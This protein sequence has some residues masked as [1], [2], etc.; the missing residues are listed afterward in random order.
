MSK[1][2]GQA[3]PAA[4]PSARPKANARVRPNDR[5]SGGS[6]SR[7]PWLIAAVVVVIGIAALVAV[8]GSGGD[9]STADTG[10]ETATVTVTGAT[11]PE[12]DGS[13][14]IAPATDPAVGKTV[15]TL[16]GSSLSGT[17]VTFG[18]TGKPTVYVFVAHWC[19]HCQAE[20]PR[21]VEWINDGSFDASGVLWRT[22]STS[23]SKDQPNYPPS[24]WLAKV[25]WD[26]PV[27]VDSANS[28]AAQAF[29]LT[30]FP[31]MLFVDGNGVVKQRATGELT[32]AEV[33]QGIAAI[34]AASG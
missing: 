8:F 24:A 33:Q 17:P 18:P 14:L 29:G 4:R 16:S 28:A 34:G 20:M 5:A 6:A 19:P 22:V 1:T 11:L 10:N 15:P 30:S 9:D 26:Q 31:Y 3:R 21:L 23:V 7:M 12:A 2:A 27:M 25:K 32:L 13:G